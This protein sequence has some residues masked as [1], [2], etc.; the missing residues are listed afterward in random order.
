MSDGTSVYLL[1]IEGNCRDI[2]ISITMIAH[3]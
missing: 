2:Y 1:N 3:N